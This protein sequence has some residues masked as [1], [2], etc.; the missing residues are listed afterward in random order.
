MW[1][2]ANETQFLHTPHDPNVLVQL[3]KVPRGIIWPPYILETVQIAKRQPL[4]EQ[5]FICVL[6]STD[7]LKV[8]SPDLKV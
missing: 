6:I 8:K 2:Q 7:K 1:L 5:I 3:S 4:I